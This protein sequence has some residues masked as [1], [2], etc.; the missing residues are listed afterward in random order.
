M[1][2][3]EPYETGYEFFLDLVS[4]YGREEGLRIANSYLD[5]QAHVYGTKFAETLPDE[6]KF[7]QEL[8]QA[9]QENRF[10]TCSVPATRSVPIIHIVR[11]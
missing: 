7:C 8:Y 11:T 9:T 10:R 1:R 3:T 5:T 2:K 6:F 4:N